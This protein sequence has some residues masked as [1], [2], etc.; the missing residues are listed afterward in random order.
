MSKPALKIAAIY[1][2]IGA[3]WIMLSD[4]FVAFIAPN[5]DAIVALST[6]KGWLYILVTAYLL[7]VLI[8]KDIAQFQGINEG[9]EASEEKLKMRIEEMQTAE[10][11]QSALYRI[12][13]KASSSHSLEDLYQFVHEV[14]SEFIPADDVNIVLYEDQEEQIRFVYRSVGH[15]GMP[16]VRTVDQ[17]LTEYVIRTGKPVLA[18][19]EV[20][21]GLAQRGE[22][23]MVG[24]ATDWL[25]V[26]LKTAN[27]IILGVMVVKNEARG[28]SC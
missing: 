22:A 26:P 9:L 6:A 21:A 23:V 25:G 24:A 16:L 14:V 17:G 3:L 10:K 19:S 27:D 13:D 12:S 7:Y 18:D 4:Q 8:K 20:L 1:A 2:V 28:G 5:A 15:D 11:L